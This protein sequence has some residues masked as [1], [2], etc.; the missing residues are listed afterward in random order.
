MYRKSFCIL[1]TV[2]VAGCMSVVTGV[3]A[4]PASAREPARVVISPIGHL[5]ADF[6]SVQSGNVE[7][8][9]SGPYWGSVTVTVGSALE[10]DGSVRA[11]RREVFSYTG[12]EEDTFVLRGAEGVRYVQAECTMLSDLNPGSIRIR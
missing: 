3:A 9:A 6:G 10:A 5:W 1:C 12:A 8:K 7:V 4:K 2:A 11:D